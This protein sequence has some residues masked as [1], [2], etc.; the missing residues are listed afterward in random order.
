MRELLQN[1]AR[2]NMRRKDFIDLNKPR[3]APDGRKLPS[4]FAQRWRDFI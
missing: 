4:F 1:K 3:H 2:A